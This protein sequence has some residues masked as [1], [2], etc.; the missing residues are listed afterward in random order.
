MHPLQ[1]E[2][3]VCASFVNT[4]LSE[5]TTN[6]SF[7]KQYLSNEKLFKEKIFCQSCAAPAFLAYLFPYVSV[8]Y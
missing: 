3:A 5:R 1:S 7:G 2:A 6:E 4:Y 8:L